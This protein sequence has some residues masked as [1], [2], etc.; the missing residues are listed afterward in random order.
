M[1]IYKQCQQYNVGKTCSKYHTLLK[2]L[3]NQ[4]KAAVF[5]EQNCKN[6][7]Q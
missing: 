4:I 1:D 7:V 5:T 3:K 2:H 6:T